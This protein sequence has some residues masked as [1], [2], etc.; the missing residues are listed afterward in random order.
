MT[1]PNCGTR[2]GQCVDCFMP[3]PIGSTAICTEE[4]CA[5]NGIT[6]ACKGC[7]LAVSDE[8]DG[9]MT[10]EGELLPWSQEDQSV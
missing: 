2:T 5:E 3:Y 6:V 4:Q 8:L 7:G 9:V 1:C 10:L